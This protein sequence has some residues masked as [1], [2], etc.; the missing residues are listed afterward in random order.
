[1]LSEREYRT[2]LVV[3]RCSF[4]LSFI[5]GFSLK[6]KVITNERNTI[7]HDSSSASF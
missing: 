3:D 5:L 7:F 2:Q 6:V 4:I 1:M